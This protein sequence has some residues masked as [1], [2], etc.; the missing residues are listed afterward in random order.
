[1]KSDDYVL[2]YLPIMTEEGKQAHF[3][4]MPL[5]DQEFDLSIL[6]EEEKIQYEKLVEKLIN[7][8]DLNNKLNE[9]FESKEKPQRFDD[10]KH[11]LA[12]VIAKIKMEL[13][14]I[15]KRHQKSTTTK[16]KREIESMRRAMKKVAFSEIY[17]KHLHDLVQRQLVKQ[18]N[19]K[20]VFI[21]LSHA[22]D[23]VDYIANILPLMKQAAECA[24]EESSSMRGRNTTTL[25]Q[26]EQI[27]K[28]ELA[29][30]VARGLHFWLD[31][32]VSGTHETD[33]PS[34]FGEF[35]SLCGKKAG[36]TPFSNKSDQAQRA[37]TALKSTT[38]D[39]D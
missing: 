27:L 10:F 3:G 36:L 22:S 29:N 2:K 16:E 33:C 14:E 37:A 6:E 5:N 9:L 28:Q 12:R 34:F 7:D 18:G 19:Y 39:Q 15:T 30:Q 31:I 20:D 38:P 21:A 11:R 35:L 24:Y 25:G 32:K 13:T 1:M 17:K 23:T 26:K 4:Q 8:D